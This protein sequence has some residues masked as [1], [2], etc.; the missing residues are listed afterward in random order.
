M[1]SE[2]YIF[3]NEE[4]WDHALSK[5]RVRGSF[6]KNKKWTDDDI[7]NML[8]Y[9][10]AVLNWDECT[11][12]GEEQAIEKFN[13]RMMNAHSIMIKHFI[14]ACTFA[15]QCVGRNN[16]SYWIDF[17]QGRGYKLVIE[18]RALGFRIA[19]ATIDYDAKRKPVQANDA[20]YKI[21]FKSSLA[22]CIEG[23][24]RKEK[25]AIYDACW[26]RSTNCS[27]DT[28]DYKVQTWHGFMKWEEATKKGYKKFCEQAEAIQDKID[29][30]WKQRTD[31]HEKY[32]KK[33]KKIAE[34][35]GADV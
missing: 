3:D 4:T 29:E 34:A 19:E 1:L 12:F 33:M 9:G 2:C 7:Y 13:D 26:S 8:R 25:N 21:Y 18:Y 15:D 11:K 23:H 35:G 30:L 14:R 17:R 5:R 6:W 27:A 20:L 24:A 10:C 31:L 16:W 32:M 28:Y 22:D